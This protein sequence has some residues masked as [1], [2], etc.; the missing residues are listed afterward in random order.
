MLLDGTA[1][2]QNAAEHLDPHCSRRPLDLEDKTRPSIIGHNKFPITHDSKPRSFAEPD[3]LELATAPRLQGSS[4]DGTT[5]PSK[6]FK[7][8]LKLLHYHLQQFPT[9]H[10]S[11]YRAEEQFRLDVHLIW[12]TRGVHVFNGSIGGWWWPP[13]RRTESVSQVTRA[14]SNWKVEA[15]AYRECLHIMSEKEV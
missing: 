7:S 2:F 8:T 10:P 14:S 12:L 5:P 4:L 15:Y 3:I 1:Y 9:A 13:E 6:W 11:P